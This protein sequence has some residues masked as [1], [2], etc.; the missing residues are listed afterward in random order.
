[1]RAAFL[2]GGRALRSVPL[3]EWWRLGAVPLTGVVGVESGV[4]AGAGWGLRAVPLMGSAG[5]GGGL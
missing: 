4:L 5:G 3:A 2:A 1:M